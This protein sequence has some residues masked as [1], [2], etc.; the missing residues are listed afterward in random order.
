M[1][2]S[3][4]L[5]TTPATLSHTFKVDET[6]TSAGAVTVAVK[7]LD[8]TTVASGAATAGTPGQYS[9][10]LAGQ[11]E[12]DTLTVDWS[13]SLG[14]ERDV[15]EIVG[16]H[17]FDLAEARSQPPPLDATKYP[18]AT[19]R[20]KRVEVEVECER[21]CGVAFVPRYER[22]VLDGS[23]GE[24]LVLPRVEIRAVRSVSIGGAIT[25]GVDFDPAGVIYRAGGASWPAGRRNVLVEYEHGYDA[26]PEDLKM[27]AMLR[28]RSRLTMTS[29]GVPDRAITWTA[30]EGGTYR[31]ALPSKTKTGVPDVDAA[32]EGHTIDMGGFA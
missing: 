21:I 22:V 28:L 31:I 6:P 12:L 11:A 14:T 2:L 29:S 1:A 23:G 32:Y 20:A 4:V 19:L 18:T 13:G 27:A 3:R 16:G 24:P 15:V 17:L 25:T 10:A 26:P 5:R 8:G 30:A 7:R 9:Y